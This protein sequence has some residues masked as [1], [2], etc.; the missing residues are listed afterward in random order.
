MSRAKKAE[1]TAKPKD[2]LANQPKPATPPK[3]PPANSHPDWE[4]IEIDYRAGVKTLRQIADEHN[5][6]HTAIRN[7]AKKHGWD[8][9][10]SAKI[11]Q[12]A[13]A[14]VSKAV[15]SSQ[16][17]AETK[18]TEREVV[19]ANALAITQIRLSHR[20]DIQRARRLAM[21]LLEELEQETGQDQVNLLIQ[22]G[23]LMF[24]PDDKGRDK[25]NEIYQKV[26]SLP[27]RAKVMKNMSDAVRV[28][29]ELERNAFGMDDKDAKD[30]DA[31]QK[32]LHS[33][34]STN[35]SAFQ[36]IAA[37]PDHEQDDA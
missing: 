36:P 1:S 12:K 3:D 33:I 30:V 28:L 14:L 24:Q 16:V 27:E 10:L 31:L 20:T 34:S 5:V 2:K 4:R 35:A 15:V 9:D 22:L 17:S 25:L 13:D 23:E 8:R 7:R 6:S 18:I 26:I 37:D 29:V 32:L 19:E 21:A 11:K